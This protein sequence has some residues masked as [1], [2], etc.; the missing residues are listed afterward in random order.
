MTLPAFYKYI[1][2]SQTNTT[3]QRTVTH[4]NDSDL[5]QSQYCLRNREIKPLLFS[6]EVACYSPATRN[7]LDKLHKRLRLSLSC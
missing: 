4:I 7:V 3:M 5:P 6:R 2:Y 1:A